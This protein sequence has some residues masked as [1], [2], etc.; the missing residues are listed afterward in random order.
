MPAERMI[1]PAVWLSFLFFTSLVLFTDDY[2]IAGILPE[3]ARDLAVS[4]GMAGQLVTVFSLTVAIAAPVQAVFLAS[5]DRKRLILAL[6]LVF[7]CANLV[8]TFATSFSLLMAMR[9]IAAL[10]AAAI[11]P[12]LFAA[13]ASMAPTEKAGRYVAVISLGVTGSIAFGVPLGTWIGAAF[14]W[15]WTF[16]VMTM[17]GVLAAIAIWIALPRPTLQ[18]S[19]GLNALLAPLISRPLLFGY[20]ANFLNMAASMLLLTYLAPV[21]LG[22]GD[23]G[24]HQRG[25]VFGVSGFAGMAGV[26]MGGLATDR[27]GALQALG[28]GM[29]AFV[30][31]MVG[32][33]IFWVLRPVPLPYLLVLVSLW[34]G[35]AFWNSPAIAARIMTLADG[36]AQQAMALNTSFTYLGVAL[37]GVLGGVALDMAGVAFLAP[38][39]LTIGILALVVLRMSR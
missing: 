18:Q 27:W 35:S 4:G 17:G 1:S 31:A 19:S 14:G 23:V 22:L 36:A 9:I 3:L 12:S 26:W 11:T 21:L 30:L 25:L 28:A 5:F 16:G 2:V 7:V 8:A 24:Q 34:A 20:L 37:G 13:A 10:C 32:L 38:T 15:R 29:T 33:T 39:S 6:L